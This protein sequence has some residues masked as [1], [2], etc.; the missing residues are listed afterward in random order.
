MIEV[1]ING[2]SVEI[3]ADRAEL[4]E[5]ADVVAAAQENGLGACSASFPGRAIVQQLTVVAEEITEDGGDDG[6]R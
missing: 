3:V 2:S 6:D 5:L 4:D 1:R